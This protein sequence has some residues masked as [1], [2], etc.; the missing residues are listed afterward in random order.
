[1]QL[2]IIFVILFIGILFSCSE[3][4]RIPLRLAD[5]HLQANELAISAE[6]R[7]E[8]DAVRHRVYENS[9][10]TAWKHMI[11]NSEVIFI[12]EVFEDPL[13]TKK[14][15]DVMGKGLIYSLFPLGKNKWVFF[16]FDEK[17][18]TRGQG[19]YAVVL[20]KGSIKS[21]TNSRKW[22][23]DSISDT[24]N[25]QPITLPNHHVCAET[26]L[27]KMINSAKVFAHCMNSGMQFNA[28][29]QRLNASK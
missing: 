1:M 13:L 29:Q 19:V 22:L 6:K 10:K 21:I 3:C 14:M 17:F 23:D 5:M 24:P 15:L 20:P 11:P 9:I 25:S 16:T 18:V 7:F 4:A 12:L 26:F 28:R 2:D 8:T 27:S